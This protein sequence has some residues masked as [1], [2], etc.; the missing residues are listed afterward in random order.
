MQGCHNDLLMEW[1]GR[2]EGGSVESKCNPEWGSLCNFS[3]ITVSFGFQLVTVHFIDDEVICINC[4]L[5]LSL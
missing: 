4:H 5:F 2:G 1:V 3:L